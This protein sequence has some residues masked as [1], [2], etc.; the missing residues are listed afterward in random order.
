LL[1][2]SLG[3]ISYHYNSFASAC[4]AVSNY[5]Q[6]L[7]DNLLKRRIKRLIGEKKI[8]FHLRSVTN[9][10]LVVGSQERILNS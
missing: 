7:K 6:M 2:F 8:A 1:F 10:D 9:I 5:Q 4:L 3:N